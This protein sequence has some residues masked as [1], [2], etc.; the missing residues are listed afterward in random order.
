VRQVYFIWVLLALGPA[1]FYFGFTGLSYAL[2]GHRPRFWEPE[3]GD[4]SHRQL[5]VLLLLLMSPLAAMLCGLW[6][7][8]LRSWSRRLAVGI[9]L[10][11][12]TVAVNY[13][14]YTVDPYGVTVWL[15]D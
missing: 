13:C 2:Y 4:S 1:L 15:K 3:M 6:C 8:R 5:V 10:A 9:V 12:V 11:L 14:I 7:G